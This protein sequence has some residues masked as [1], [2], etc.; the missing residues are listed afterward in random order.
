MAAMTGPVEVLEG[1]TTAP[2]R[3]RHR[4]LMALCLIALVAAGG[5]LW[6]NWAAERAVR[7]AVQ[8][9]AD[10]GVDSSSAS[11]PGGAVRYFVMVGNSGARP[12]S[13]TSVTASSG[14]LRVRAQEPGPYRVDVRGEVEIVLS[15][16]LTCAGGVDAN[17]SLPATLGVRREDGSTLTRRVELRP[18]SLVLG[19]AATLC[20]TRPGLSDHE[21]SGPVVRR[22]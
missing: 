4:V 2:E 1:G 3:R 17:G 20:A 18:A 21:L 10:F 11:P 13:I 5:L 12:I 16:R 15:V 22:G 19:V 14:G 6:R 7:Q 9:T 8:L